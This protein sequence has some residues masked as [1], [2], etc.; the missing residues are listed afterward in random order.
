[1]EGVFIKIKGGFRWEKNHQIVQVE[2]W[3]VNGVRVRA[4]PLEG[5]LELP[6][7]LLPNPA[8]GNGGEGDDRIEI[9]PGKAALTKG[10]VRLEMDEEGK[11]SFFKAGS[12]ELL[13][14][15][16]MPMFWRPPA[17]RF[18]PRGSQSFQLTARFAAQEGEHFYGL[19]QHQH[20]L[21]NQKGAVIELE[22]RNTEVCIPFL[23]SSRGY[24]F[25]WNNPAVGRVELGTNLT[26]WI[27]ESTPQMDYL[28]LAGDTPAEIL[29]GY[30]DATGHPPRLP[31]FA[32][33]F[34]QCKL[35]YSNQEEL[36]EVAREYKRRGLPLD[37]IVV[38]YFHWTMMGDWKFDPLYWPDPAAMVKELDELGVKLMVSVWPSVNS[39]SPNYETMRQ[40][41]LLIRTEQGV[42][43]HIPVGDSFPPGQSLASYYDSTHP[44]GRKFIW[45]QV[46]KN[47]YDYGI[48]VYWLDACE[49]E[50]YPMDPQ[51]LRFHLGSGL[52]VGHLFPLMHHQAFA[53][54]MQAAG[55]K[56]FIFLSRS[57]WAGSQRYGAAVWSGDVPSTFEFFRKQV[58]AGLNIAMS[59]IPWWTT[60]IGGFLGGDPNSA[61]FRELI[62][63]WFQ[64]GLFC[65]LFRLHGV[66]LPFTEDGR[67]SGTGAGN[68]VWS[69]GEKAYEIIRGLLHLREKLKPYIMKQMQVASE[70]GLPPMRPLFV[71]YPADPAC[72]EVEDQ[73]NFGSDLLVAP[74]LYEGQRT[75]KLYLPQGVAWMDAWDGK[76]YTGGQWIEAA[77]PL[78]RIPVFW[79]QASEDQFLFLKE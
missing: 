27:A 5:L 23:V 36:L 66:R 56:E 25:L 77:A 55:E 3:G 60:D 65:P 68:E 1:M 19:G 2:A 26:R 33:G 10:K 78:E 20:G 32:A 29:E 42:Q 57:A 8:Q 49:P 6:G 37:V 61:Y 40:R 52:E 14:T 73:F 74:V 31:E 59:G 18:V 21:L 72:W 51:N 4:T 28:V 35:R 48:K 7:A 44:E 64:Y 45:E 75:R 16:E 79:R 47:Y 12:G 53:D 63:R 24:G 54:G 71:D 43:A 41:G 22:E 9:G 38:D 30:A 39:N 50:I 70:K 17:R 76:E 34:W 62:V 13:L 46:K 67:G 69:F 11:L 58:P 15:E